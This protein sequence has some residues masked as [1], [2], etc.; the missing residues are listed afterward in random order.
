MDA[1]DYM[2]AENDSVLNEKMKIVMC[3]KI[4][5]PNTN[6]LYLPNIIGEKKEPGTNTKINY[7][8]Q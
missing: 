8:K 7:G 4:Q 1:A 5:P 2:A 6:R 3:I